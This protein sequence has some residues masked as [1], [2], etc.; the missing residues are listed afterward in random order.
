MAKGWK[1]GDDF[2]AL[3]KAGNLPSWSTV[4]QRY[5]KNI[6]QNSPDLYPNV[7]GY[8]NLARMKK[9]LAPKVDDGGVICSMELHHPRG[10]EGDNFWIFEPVTPKQ[11]AARD[12]YRH[13]GR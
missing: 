6:A 5:W 7:A 13:L 9:G 8:D 2:K 3:T 1:V 4:R 10:R 12:S 11:H